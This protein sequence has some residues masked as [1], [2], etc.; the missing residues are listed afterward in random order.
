[1]DLDRLV[2]AGQREDL[3][4]V[5]GQPGRDEPSA[6]PLGAD[7]ERHEEPDATAVHVLELAE[8]EDDGHR[9]VGRREA[10]CGHEVGFAGR[11]D[12]ACDPQDGCGT[13]LIEP[14]DGGAHAASPSTI[15]M[16]SDRR[17][18]RKISR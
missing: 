10:I 8:V 4:V 7:K 12:I 6:S 17:V 16:K 11:G 9:P 1:V 3:A 14:D 13:V 2:E 15:S 5:V 18:I